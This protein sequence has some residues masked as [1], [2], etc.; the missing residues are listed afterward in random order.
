MRS[1]DGDSGAPTRQPYLRQLA[2]NLDRLVIVSAFVEPSFRPGLVDRLL[3]M[4]EQEN[5]QAV[6]VLN[7][8]DLPCENG[9]HY[10]QLYSSLG[11]PTCLTSTLTG[12]GID[13]LRSWLNGSSALCG[14]SGVG[15]SSLLRALAPEL[16]PQ[17]DEVSLATGKGQHTTTAVRLYSTEWGELFDLPGLKLAPLSMEPGELKRYFPEF[18]ACRCRFRDCL[19]QREPGCGVSVALRDELVDEERYESYLRILSSL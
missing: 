1:E 14:H 11:Y 5:L 2:P 4:A 8:A 10:R 12:L 18:S 19:H 13:Q 17:T 7:K 15:K 3:V 9:E 16:Q 6:V